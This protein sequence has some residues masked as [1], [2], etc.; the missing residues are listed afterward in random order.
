MK[1]P[2]IPALG[3][4][5]L[6]ACSPSSSFSGAAPLAFPEAP[7][8]ADP[9]PAPEEPA[10]DEAE[11]APLPQSMDE[12]DVP[13]GFDFGTAQSVLVEVRVTAPGGAPY[14][15]VEV[16]V[17]EAALE[18]EPQ[19]LAGLVTDAAGVARTRVTVSG[20]VSRLH[21]RANAL[22]IVNETEAAIA[23]GFADIELR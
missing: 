11:A 8:P 21:V 5:A 3:L 1:A 20:G 7:A 14:S 17:S 2:L 16:F 18:G 6:S 4:L 15:G 19:L 9:L 12:L 10:G 22:G 23:D 13:A